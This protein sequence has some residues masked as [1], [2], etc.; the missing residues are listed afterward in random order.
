MADLIGRGRTIRLDVLTNNVRAR[1][2]YERLGLVVNSDS[3]REH[4]LSMRR[5]PVAQPGLDRRRLGPGS[6]CSVRCM[7]PK[8]DW[9]HA[10]W[11]P[12]ISIVGT[13]LRLPRFGTLPATCPFP[14]RIDGR[15]HG[16][17]GWT[18]LD[19]VFDLE[20]GR[21]QQPDHVSVA[22]ME[23]HRVDDSVLVAP[24]ETVHAEIVPMQHG[25]RRERVIFERVTDVCERRQGYCQQPATGAK[26]AAGL[27]Y[28]PI[29]VAPESDPVFRD[30]EVEARV[31]KRQDLPITLNKREVEIELVLQPRG[32]GYLLPGA[33]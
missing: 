3:E 28:P 5:D 13:L 7:P 15:F 10:P 6:R 33:V 14:S 23:I 25:V 12:E 20:A 21:P 2:F 18:D 24:V 30:R 29:R 8:G 26:H 1:R 31:S 17:I 11:P 32:M 27:G 16:Y 9:G 22:E 4:Y 19:Q